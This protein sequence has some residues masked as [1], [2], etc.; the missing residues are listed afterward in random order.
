MSGDG[1]R[2]RRNPEPDTIERSMRGVADGGAWR[3]VVGWVVA[4]QAHNGRLEL[5]TAGTV[6]EA[7]KA[8]RDA[9]RDTWP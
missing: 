4:G 9:V 7:I 8:W 2:F 1:K 5:F 6:D 3:D